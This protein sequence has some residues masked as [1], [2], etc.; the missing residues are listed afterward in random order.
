MS[1]IYY[2]EEIVDLIKVHLSDA[3][4]SEIT[5]FAGD[6][7]EVGNIAL[8]NRIAGMYD[9]IDLVEKDLVEKEDD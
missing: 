8:R 5:A 2:Q 4:R 1:K 3:I 7:T 9:L 6:I